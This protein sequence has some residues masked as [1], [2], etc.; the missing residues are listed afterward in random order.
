MTIKEIVLR[1]NNKKIFTEYIKAIRHDDGQLEFLIERKIMKQTRTE[2]FGLTPDE[3]KKMIDF[4]T[5]PF[6][7][8]K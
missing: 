2:G 5:K 1:P 8:L 6:E 3:V 4:V 7:E